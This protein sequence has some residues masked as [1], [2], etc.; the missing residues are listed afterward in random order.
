[1]HGFL[2]LGCSGMESAG[3]DVEENAVT[4]EQSQSITATYQGNEMLCLL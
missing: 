3:I 2:F 1:V 4:Q